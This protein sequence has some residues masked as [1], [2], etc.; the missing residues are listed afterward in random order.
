VAAGAENP[1]RLQWNVPVAQHL[2]WSGEQ[3]PARFKPSASFPIIEKR[4]PTK[5]Q[6][7]TR[8][9]WQREAKHDYA[10]KN[11]QSMKKEPKYSYKRRSYALD[12]NDQL[13]A[14]ARRTQKIRDENR[15]HMIQKLKQRCLELG[16]IQAL[17]NQIDADGDGSVTMKELKLALLRMNFTLIATDFPI[18]FNEMDTNGD[19]VV[20]MGELDRYLKNPPRP[21]AGDN[22]CM[23]ITQIVH[24]YSPVTYG[25]A[26]R[27]V[28]WEQRRAQQ[29]EEQLRRKF[30]D[31]AF[32]TSTSHLQLLK[33]GLTVPDWAAVGHTNGGGFK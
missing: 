28:G 31:S 5:K 1:K 13:I 8:A 25:T 22:R 17:F 21:S 18:Y 15:I 14:K 10:E 6:K 16:S 7:P 4:S 3:K 30:V 23:E 32:A 29:T 11:M 2:L 9:P 27:R 24:R 19:G 20:D 33:A 26:D 12:D